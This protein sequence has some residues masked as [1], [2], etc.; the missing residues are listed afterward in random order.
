MV[1]TL[2]YPKE[3]KKEPP[4]KR[5]LRKLCRQYDIHFSKRLPASHFMLADV[6]AQYHTLLHFLLDYEA[7]PPNVRSAVEAKCSLLRRNIERTVAQLNKT[8]RPAGSEQTPQAPDAYK[9][10]AAKHVQAAQA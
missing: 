10:S 3:L 4:Y 7:G 6:L 8:A 2:P 5:T 1:V 9:A